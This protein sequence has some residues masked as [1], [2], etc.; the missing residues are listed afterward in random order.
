[1]DLPSGIINRTLIDHL[2]LAVAISTSQGKLSNPVL[3][4]NLLAFIFKSSL[5]VESSCVPSDSIVE[6]IEFAVEDI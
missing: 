2:L 5:I 1:M 6:R 4:V 3:S